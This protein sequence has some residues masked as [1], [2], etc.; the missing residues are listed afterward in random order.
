M[1]ISVAALPVSAKLIERG[2]TRVTTSKCNVRTAGFAKM[3]IHMT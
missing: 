3:Q 2:A 1:K